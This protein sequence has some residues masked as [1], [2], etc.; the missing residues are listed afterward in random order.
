MIV[1]LG[2]FHRREVNYSLTTAATLT[3][4][5]LDTVLGVGGALL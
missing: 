3:N 5:D 2:V 4:T 1:A